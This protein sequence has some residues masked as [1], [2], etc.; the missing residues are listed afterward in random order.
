[1]SR[2]QPPTQQIKEFLLMASHATY[3]SGDPSIRKVM[4]DKSTTITYT[5]GDFS[6]HDNYFGG[7]PYGGR[8]VIFYKEKPIW[9]MVYYGTVVN[10]IE[11]KI[12]YPILTKAL[13]ASTIELPYRG[14]KLFEFQG[15]TYKNKFTGSFS[16][17]TGEEYIY[18]RSVL[19]Y[20]ANFIG[21]Y[22]DRR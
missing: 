16:N 19:L 12:V 14:P 11:P 18:R 6:F 22:I 21:G 2:Q 17:F 7:E 10:N 5:N 8:E 1:M 15:L 9:I 4:P 13:Q 20:K 3:A